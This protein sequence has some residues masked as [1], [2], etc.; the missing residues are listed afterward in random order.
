MFM[1]ILNPALTHLIIKPTSRLF[2]IVIYIAMVRY[3]T[4]GSIAGANKDTTGCH[5]FLSILILDA[6]R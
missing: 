2:Q 6:T 5:A 4:V 3:P 1:A